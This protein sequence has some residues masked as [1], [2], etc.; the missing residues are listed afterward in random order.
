MS[1]KK[2]IHLDGGCEKSKAKGAVVAKKDE[3]IDCKRCEKKAQKNMKEFLDGIKP[4]TSGIMAH[5]TDSDSDE[6]VP[7]E[8]LP[9]E[10]II[11]VVVDSHTEMFNQRRVIIKKNRE[12][13]EKGVKIVELERKNKSLKFWKNVFMVLI[14]IDILFWI[15]I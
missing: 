15:F 10:K 8:K 6:L 1:K 11:E 5:D 7:I 9:K 4:K 14:V 12:I 2:K 13:S 3:N